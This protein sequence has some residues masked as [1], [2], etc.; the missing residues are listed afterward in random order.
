MIISK[1]SKHI[2]LSG[3]HDAKVLLSVFTQILAQGLF[4]EHVEVWD[5]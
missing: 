2:V 4:L 1:I 5:L 3:D